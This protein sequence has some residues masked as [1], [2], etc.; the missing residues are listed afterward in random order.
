MK[1]KKIVITGAP[2]T[3]KTSLIHALEKKGYFCLNEISRQI[4][5]EA[6]QNGISQLFL[7]DPLLFSELLLE[8]RIK[9]FMMAENSGSGVVFLDRGIPDVTAY[10][11]FIRKEYPP[12]FKKAASEHQYEEVFLLPPWKEIYKPDNERYESFDQASAIHDFLSK[13]YSGLG[14]Q[15]VELPFGTI[16]ERI[17]FILDKLPE[18]NDGS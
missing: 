17:S 5:R 6:Q 13:T 4:T 16:E 10:M 3:G 15:P 12:A 2:G 1:S 7:K 8:G 18:E 9:Q 14:Y 11:D